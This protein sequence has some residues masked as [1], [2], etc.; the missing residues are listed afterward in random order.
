MLLS[1]QFPQFI[2]LKLETVDNYTV[3]FNV[4]GTVISHLKAF[5]R[6]IT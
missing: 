5:T 2:S 3:K 4:L 6:K 1:A